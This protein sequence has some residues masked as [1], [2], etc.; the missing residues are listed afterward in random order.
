M[1]VARN[2]AGVARG[3]E[4]FVWHHWPEHFF[5]SYQFRRGLGETQEGGGAVSEL[6]QAA[7][8]MQPGDA[9]S[10]HVEWSRIAERN[11]ARGDED[12]LWFMTGHGAVQRGIAVLL[13]DGPGQ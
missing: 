11:D 4:P 8:R 12:E 6:F 5:L 2:P 3:Y 13:V 7:T 1:N 9:Q 10:W